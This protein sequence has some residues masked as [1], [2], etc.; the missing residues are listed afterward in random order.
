MENLSLQGKIY[1]VCQAVYFVILLYGIVLVK[2]IA[3][4]LEKK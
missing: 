1:V 3:K 4:K 2:N